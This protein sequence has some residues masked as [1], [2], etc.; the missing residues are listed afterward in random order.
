M[1]DALPYADVGEALR[2]L[3][4][5]FLALLF[6]IGCDVA[7]RPAAPPP[8][9]PALPSLSLVDAANAGDFAQVARL[10]E[11]GADA[12]AAQ[13]EGLTAL[14]VAAAGGRTEIV[15]LLIQR[16]ARMDAQDAAGSTP[17]HAAAR[18][19][20]LPAVQELVEA[21]APVLAQ[22]REGQTPMQVATLLQHAGVAF[23]LREHGGAGEEA[24]IEAPVEAEAPAPG[25]W[26]TGATFRVWTSAGGSTVDAEF[27]QT[28]LDTVLL[29][30][31]NGNL[32]R[33]GLS[34]LTP[35]DQVLARQLAGSVP[36]ALVR[37]RAAASSGDRGESIGKKVG[38][39]NGWTTLEGCT[40]LRQSANDGDSFHVRHGG[41]EYI[42]RLYY[43]DAAETSMLFPDRVEDQARYF[44]V[45]EPD[46]LRLG[47][48][49][50]KFSERI[51]GSAAF[52]VVT[53]WEDARGNSQLPRFYALVSTPQGDLDELLVA[54]GLA[55]RYGMPVGGGW[56]SRK[57]AILKRL[58]TEAR[59]D[60]VGAWGVGRR[61]A[62]ARE[63]PESP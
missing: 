1:K 5:L 49:A 4:P 16:G 35:E 2:R 3:A 11:E 56:G 41:Q 34:L 14:H 47:H 28:V 8:P 45:G 7:R 36:P 27:V 44:R 38:E 13:G 55:R 62:A 30:E 20:R 6:S 31:H 22:D 25:V 54:E 51:L 58:E 50:K 37:S 48:E 53:K 26:L 46:A 12:N 9:P 23:Y 33:I 15:R 21:G 39:E 61:E 42:F 32:V 40:L 18:A 19:G 10:L 57:D 60:R 52:T 59:H 43:V 63:V 17:L 29:R 24:V